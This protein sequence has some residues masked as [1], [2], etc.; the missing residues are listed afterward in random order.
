MNFYLVLISHL[1]SWIQL[2]IRGW[3]K[4]VVGISLPTHCYVGWKKIMFLA[5]IQMSVQLIWDLEEKERSKEEITIS[6]IIT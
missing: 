6:E 4:G 5:L 2:I 3:V 1:I